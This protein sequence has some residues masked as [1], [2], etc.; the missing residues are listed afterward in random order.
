M[1]DHY[2]TDSI[3]TQ[4]MYTCI[5]SRQQF[6]SADKEHILQNFLG[7][8]WASPVIVCNEVQQGFSTSIDT[9]LET[10]LKEYRILL[11]SEGGRGGEPR[12]LKVETTAGRT[13]LIE[14]GGGAKLAEPRVVVPDPSKPDQLGVEMRSARDAGWVAKKIRELYPT[15]DMAKL[16]TTLAEALKTPPP[17]EV[18]PA[19]RLHLQVRFGGDEFFRGALKAIFNLLGVSDTKLALESIFDSVRQFILKGAGSPRSFVRWPI[20][21]P[22]GLPRLADFDH[23]IAVFS[24][25]AH[26]EAFVQFFGT[27]HWACRLASGY[28]GP[29]FCCAYLVDPTR[30]ADPAEDRSPQVSVGMFVPFESARPENDEDVRRHFQAQLETFLRLHQGRVAEAWSG[31]VVNAIEGAWG[32][33]DGRPLTQKDFDRAREAIEELVKRRLGAEN[34]P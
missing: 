17:A 22:S 24:R 26:V 19:D 5:Y 4:S 29:E 31:D 27:I 3:P 2:Q 13:V 30:E 7:A 33:S 28:T 10:G 6:E 34:K 23:L 9:A 21:G 16:M 1:V 20:A 12:A 15:A 14:P 25:G 8:R 18:D 11:G 32:T